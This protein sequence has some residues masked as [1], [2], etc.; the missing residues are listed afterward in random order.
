MP[1]EIRRERET[2][3]VINPGTSATFPSFNLCFPLGVSTTILIVPNN[4][5]W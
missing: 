3:L 1:F 2:K 5:I 4:S